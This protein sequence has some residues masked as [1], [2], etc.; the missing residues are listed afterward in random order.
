V[1]DARSNVFFG[2]L[3]IAHSPQFQRQLWSN[4][5]TL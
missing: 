2:P 5:E 3:I 1:I 4:S